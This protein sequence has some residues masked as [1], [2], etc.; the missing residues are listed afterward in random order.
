MKNELALEVFMLPDSFKLGSK[1]CFVHITIKNI[2]DHTITIWNKG[3][4][5]NHRGILTTALNEEVPMTAEGMQR[6]NAFNGGVENQKGI[7]IILKKGE[8]Y[9]A[10]TPVNI[11]NLYRVEKTGTYYFQ[12]AFKDE[13]TDEIV[14]NKL[15]VRF[16]E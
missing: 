6:K 4:W 8:V 7:E 16:V 12:I 5:T 11:C 1:E 10:Y 14:S 3:F 2:S 15:A 9:D 13:D